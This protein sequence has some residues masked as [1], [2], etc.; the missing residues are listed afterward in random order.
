MNKRKDF[1][2]GKLILKKITLSKL[3]ATNIKGGAE[4]DYSGTKKCTSAC[5]TL[6]GTCRQCI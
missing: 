4:A 1:T 5:P 3:H 2:K 6:V